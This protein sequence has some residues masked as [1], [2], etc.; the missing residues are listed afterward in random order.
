MTVI[1]E[2]QDLET[3]RNSAPSLFFPVCVGEQGLQA[4]ENTKPAAN[5]A[6]FLFRQAHQ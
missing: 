2:S 3:K 5:A 1:P 4:P 6:G